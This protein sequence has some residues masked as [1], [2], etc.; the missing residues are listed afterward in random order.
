MTDV[1][2][3]RAGPQP[4]GALY[5]PDSKQQR[6]IP[7][8]ESSKCLNGQSYRERL[9]KE[10]FWLP[11]TR[12]SKKDPDRATTPGAE[13]TVSLHSWLHQGAHKPSSCT[14]LML[15]PHG[16]ELPQVKKSCV[17]ACRVTWVVSDSLQSYGLWPAGFLCQGGSP[18]KNIGVCWPI[19]VA[20]PSR[21][22]YFLLS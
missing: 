5:V 19:L 15:N 12:G 7:A 6:R 1:Q 10:A 16:A 8:R 14:T 11:A 9:A 3:Y 21:A 17:Y 22:L 13:A 20:C 2:N 18:G 4:G